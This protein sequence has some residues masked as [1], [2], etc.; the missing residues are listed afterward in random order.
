MSNSKER[1]EMESECSVMHV[2]TE[3]G[4]ATRS[5]RVP[6]RQMDVIEV[7]GKDT[8]KS[9]APSARGSCEDSNGQ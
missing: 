4:A 2:C 1:E 9:Y 7:K 3:Y 6:D 8:I 5:S